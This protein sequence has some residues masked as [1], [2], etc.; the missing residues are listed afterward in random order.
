MTVGTSAR[1]LRA[2][3]RPASIWRYSR[4]AQ[5]T[6]APVS[7]NASVM[8]DGIFLSSAAAAL[9]RAARALLE[10]ATHDAKCA[11]LSL[12]ARCVSRH[13]VCVR[14]RERPSCWL[15]FFSSRPAAAAPSAGPCCCVLRERRAFFS[16]R[17]RRVLAQGHARPVP[18]G[19]RQKKKRRQSG[20]SSLSP[21]LDDALHACG[22]S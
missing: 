14:V 17:C 15:L 12:H 20:C 9:S 21:A 7:G 8:R 3:A 2:P 18:L 5:G 1:P 13:R 10:R 16:R 19:R 4:T 11:P 6:R 22:R